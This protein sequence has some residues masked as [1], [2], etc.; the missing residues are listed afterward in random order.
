MTSGKPLDEYMSWEELLNHWLNKFP[1]FRGNTKFKD[2]FMNNEKNG[3]LFDRML[4]A[5]CWKM[6]C[7]LVDKNKDHFALVTGKEGYGKSSLAIQMASWIDPKFCDE[8][9]TFTARE[10]AT[11]LKVAEPGSCIVID[12]GGVIMFSREAMTIKNIEM[13]HLF[14]LQRQSNISV[15]LCCPAFFNIDSYIRTNR[16]NSL[17]RVT[18]QGHYV[19]YLTKA[20]DIINSLQS[21][22]KKI[23]QMKL[24]SG[25]FWHGCFRKKFPKCI[26]LKE[27]LRRKKQN[28][29]QFLDGIDTDDFEYMPIKR[30][31]DKL[32]IDN[33]QLINLIEHNEIK[34]KKIGKKW[35]VS[36]D[37][38]KRVLDIE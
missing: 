17:F 22:K 26:D 21:T 33:E 10:Y 37:E 29:V 1:Q 27:Y 36:K 7:D 5:R 19:G 6:H 13:N 15:I 12:E 11:R 28:Y 24:P 3:W 9:I 38:Y 18:E 20:I 30:L 14:M 23:S 4:I 8:N 16:I 34:A 25:S 2:W 32:S 31:A 35:F